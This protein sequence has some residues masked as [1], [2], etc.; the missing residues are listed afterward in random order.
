MTF[1]STCDGDLGLA[2]PLSHS[3]FNGSLSEWFD[4]LAAH[5]RGIVGG[6]GISLWRRPVCGWEARPRTAAP[7][8]S[9]T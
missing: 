9:G 4:F 5:Y 1:G 6:A 2:P 8:G 7:R 3:D